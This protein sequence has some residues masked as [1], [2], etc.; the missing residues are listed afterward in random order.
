MINAI[1]WRN[2]WI[3]LAVIGVSV[4]VPLG[5]IFIRR[6]PEDLGMLPDGG[7]PEGPNDA[8]SGARRGC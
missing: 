6:Q 3:V 5:A 8:S 1:G 2:A 7:E 4:I